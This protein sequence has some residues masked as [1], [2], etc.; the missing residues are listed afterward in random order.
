M[1]KVKFL[2][3]DELAVLLKAIGLAGED[4]VESVEININDLLIMSEHITELE[5][6]IDV[7][8]VDLDSLKGKNRCLNISLAK[9][10]VEALDRAV[11]LDI[12]SWFI[13]LLK[14]KNNERD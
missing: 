9:N 3:N 12:Y 2:A 10:Q 1:S 13:K 7:L 14:R 8:E 5:Q 11:R 6:T 4:E